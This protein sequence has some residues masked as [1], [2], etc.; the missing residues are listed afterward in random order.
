M[1]RRRGLTALGVAVLAAATA[2][3]AAQDSEVAPS[4]GTGQP[5]E[6]VQA[7]L[8]YRRASQPGAEHRWLDPLEGRWQVE[9]GWTG[10]DGTLRRLVGE[11]ENRWVLGGRFL[12]G[13]ASVIEDGVPVESLSLYGFDANQNR[14][15]ALILD[16][17][18]TDY[19]ELLGTYEP[20][21]RSF[22]FSGTER[23]EISG[24]RMTYR[25]RLRV[26]SPDQ[27]TVELFVDLQGRGPVKVLDA[28]YSRLGPVNPLEVP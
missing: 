7:L 23:D 5:S 21:A 19:L 27:H 16:S 22:V 9:M 24:V 1:A 17:L 28:T 15:F 13:E 6:L 3:G 25:L 18:G 4:P 26:A 12:S 8:A 14:F 20:A 11:A 2:G 10:S